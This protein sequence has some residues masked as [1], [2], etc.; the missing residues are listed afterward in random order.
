MENNTLKANR[1]NRDLLFASRHK[2]QLLQA[3][4]CSICLVFYETKWLSI[5]S[6]NKIKQ[7]GVAF[8]R[9]RCGVLPPCIK[10]WITTNRT[11]CNGIDR[12]FEKQTIALE[13]FQF[14]GNAC[15]SV[16]RA[17]SSD[18]AGS[19]S[20]VPVS[21]TILCEILPFRHNFKSWAIFYG[22]FSILAKFWYYCGQ[23]VLPLGKFSL[24]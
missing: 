5:C 16:G 2:R 24:L 3:V 15:G 1:N 21:V 4:K 10:T 19:R 20:L 8:R 9:P 14:K 11:F 17:I 22:L 23:T 18:R 12:R 6:F 13:I 7:D